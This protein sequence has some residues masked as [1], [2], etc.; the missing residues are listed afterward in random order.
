MHCIRNRSR[1]VIRL[2]L[3]VSNFN[4][5]ICLKCIKGRNLCICTPLNT[6]LLDFSPRSFRPRIPE[7]WYLAENKPPDWFGSKKNWWKRLQITMQ[8]SQF[9][10]L[11]NSSTCKSPSFS[12]KQVFTG[13][14]V[15]PDTADNLPL[16]K[17][18][19]S[20]G[21][22]TGLSSPR[23]PFTFW[24]HGGLVPGKQSPSDFTERSERTT[25]Y[26]PRF[27]ILFGQSFTL[28]TKNFSNRW[29]GALSWREPCASPR[30]RS[31]A[32]SGRARGDRSRA[33]SPSPSV[34]WSRRSSLANCQL[35]RNR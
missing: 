10:F 29:W 8:L 23:W 16:R 4:I 19:Q 6:K 9:W 17:K 12:S 26:R 7:F 3:L 20:S 27:S 28:C 30:R 2:I 15:I 34:R 13:H 32:S 21:R 31:W 5:W 25:M 1:K 33:S 22:Q 24:R 35:E 11:R 18:G 14:V